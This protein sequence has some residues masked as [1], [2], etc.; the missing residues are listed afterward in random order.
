MRARDLGPTASGTYLDE[1]WSMRRHALVLLALCFPAGLRAETPRTARGEVIIIEDHLPP[2]VLPKPKAFDP[3]KAP[4]YSEKAILTDAWTKAHVL[5]DVSA[6]GKVTRFKF[7]K[8][9]GYDLEP[10][11][12]K[13]LATL[14]FEPALDTKNRPRRSLVVWT[15]EW[16]SAAFLQKFVGTITKMPPIKEGT[17]P[18]RRLDAYIPCEGSGKPWHMDSHHKIYKDC[19]KPDLSKRHRESWI[20]L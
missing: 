6:T 20:A 12:A 16:P 7:L 10:I 3:R 15:I 1:A 4:P 13:Q 17:Y 19:S 14:R 18:P 9:P 11:T 5:L 2:K 8:R